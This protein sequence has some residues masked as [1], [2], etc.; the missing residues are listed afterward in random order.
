[1]RVLVIDDEPDILLLCRLILEADGH[2]VYEADDGTCGVD[3]VRCLLPDLVIIDL[4]LPDICGAEVINQIQAISPSTPVI[5]LTADV[6]PAHIWQGLDAGAVAYVTKPFHPAD[7]IA[8]VKKLG[9]LNET[10]R[11]DLRDRMLDTLALSV[12]AESLVT[13]VFGENFKSRSALRGS[14]PDI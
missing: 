7:L 3:I 10:G 8:L 9:V 2:H 1:M 14:A 13:P 6:L 11:A 5:I 4:I 12:E